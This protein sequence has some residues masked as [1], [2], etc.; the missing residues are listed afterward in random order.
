MEFTGQHRDDAFP[1]PLPLGAGN[2]EW[3]LFVGIQGMGRQDV[4]W[5]EKKSIHCDSSFPFIDSI[6]KNVI[7]SF[8]DK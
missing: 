1:L 2:A 4:L 5:Q 8:H 7:C 3:P 6:L